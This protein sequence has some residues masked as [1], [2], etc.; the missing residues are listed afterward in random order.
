[1]DTP[2]HAERL[3]SGDLAFSS[4]RPVG[5]VCRSRVPVEVPTKVV[6]TMCS[7][8][9]YSLRPPASA[10]AK[11]SPRAGAK[12]PN[13]P[14]EVASAGAS[15][16]SERLPSSSGRASSDGRASSAAWSAAATT[17]SSWSGRTAARD[18]TPTPRPTMEITVS[19]AERDTPLV[20]RVLPA[21]RRLALEVS[22]T[23]TTLSSAVESSRTLSIIS[24]GVIPFLSRRTSWPAP[25]P[26]RSPC[27]LN[28]HS[29]GRC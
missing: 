18:T 3:M 23:I 14:I 16:S 1:M 29:P 12:A 11:V 19:C 10:V 8:N 25:S 24:W 20:V 17:S 26:T 13:T 28:C 9:P 27:V 22:S 6:V 4:R 15:Q 5:W 2:V 7:A 21:K